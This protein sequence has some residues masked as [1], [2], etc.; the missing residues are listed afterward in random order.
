MSKAF[1]SDFSEH[2]LRFYMRHTDPIFKGEADRRNYEV[3][4]EVLENLTDGDREFI[5][6]IFSEG[7]TIA[8]NIYKLSTVKSI[9]QD[10]I[11]KL[12]NDVEKKIAILRGIA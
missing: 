12:V 9:P 1:Y 6:F 7:D 10:R 5:T 3:C 4:E 11:W 8:D 2:C